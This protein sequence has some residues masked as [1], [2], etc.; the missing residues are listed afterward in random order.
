ML[1]VSEY[2]IPPP[3]EVNWTVNVQVPFCA[4]GVP[5]KHVLFPPVLGST[6]NCPAPVPLIL[7]LPLNVNAVAPLFVIVSVSFF[8]PL[9]TVP[10]ASAVAESVTSVAVPVSGN[11][12]E[13]FPPGSP[14]NDA[15]ILPPIAP[16]DVGLKATLNAQVSLVDNDVAPPRLQ[17]PLEIPVVF[18]AKFALGVRLFSVSVPVPVYLKV[19]FVFLLTVFTSCVANFTVAGVNTS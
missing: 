8:I 13:V 15:V 5:L 6:L 16:A 4:T 3:V 14:E 1:I 10:N 2:E 12:T 17:A 9:A 7:G 11:C 19:T 18:T